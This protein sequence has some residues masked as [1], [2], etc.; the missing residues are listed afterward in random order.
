MPLIVDVLLKQE[1]DVLHGSVLIFYHLK[2]LIGPLASPEHLDLLRRV[3]LALGLTGLDRPNRLRLIAVT[4]A[5]VWPEGEKLAN[6]SS[7]TATT[8]GL[9]S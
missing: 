8:I 6:R 9:G 7:R 4:E 1:Q 2:Q 3:A 5:E